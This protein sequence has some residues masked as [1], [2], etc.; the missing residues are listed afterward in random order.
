MTLD[1]VNN[2]LRKQNTE[3]YDTRLCQQP[4]KETKH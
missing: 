3:L 2:R 4:V 1:Y